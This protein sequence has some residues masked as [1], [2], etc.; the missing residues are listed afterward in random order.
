MQF[1]FRASVIGLSVLSAAAGAT[2]AEAQEGGVVVLPEIVISAT[3][4]PTGDGGI[5][6][7]KVPAD[8]TVI[9]AKD[10]AQQYKPSVADTITAR[11]PAAIA[12]NVDG[13]DL[14]PDLFYR[15]F[16]AS[17]IS[18]TA[19]GLAVYENGVRINESFGDAVNLD[20]IPPIAIASA[21][22]YT[23]NPIFGLNALGGAIVFTT[24]NGF[25]FQ[26]GDVSILGGSYGRAN[27]Y[28]EFGKQVGNY[29]FYVAGDVYRDGGYRPFGAQNAQRFLA[30]L[31]YRSQDSEIHAIGSF[32]RSLLGVQGVTPQVLVNQ[33][34]NSV[35]TTP[36]TTNNQA[37]SAQLTGRF[38][39]APHWQVA[40]NFYIRQFDQ[41]H[42]DG[43]DA[44][45]DDC[46]NIDQNGDNPGTLCQTPL[47]NQTP[48]SSTPYQFIT[49]NGGTIASQG[50]NFAYGTTARTATHTLS[51]GTQL[52]ATNNQQL[53]GHDN[54]FVVA[55]QHRCRHD[56]LFV[57]DLARCPEPAVPEHRSRLP[58]RRRDPQHRRQ[59][60][61]EL[62]LRPRDRDLLRPLRARHLQHHQAA[63]RDRRRPLQRRQHRPRRP[64]RRQSGPQL[65]GL[66]QPDQPGRRPDLHVLSGA[67]RL[68]RL[69]RGEPRPDPRSK[70]PVPT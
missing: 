42:V 16:D 12:L 37:G 61:R 18:G 64:E 25:N 13:S 46:S 26:G 19:E 60:R 53:Y 6:I 49:P 63:R 39:V 59:H 34:Y 9:S 45:V 5:D 10:F 23:N 33:Q 47:T 66:L 56:E 17:R 58:R 69:F 54:Y 32:G 36:Q 4:V 24:K 21:D 51:A 28:G 65:L 55:R 67:D 68:R 70:T 30:D 2:S 38:D 7:N 15:G 40:S 3:P 62:D 22:V 44:D 43:N 50:G 35:F 31:G 8:V 57:D 14:S 11:T 41:Y 27:A 52:Q 1:T 29:S 20:L 48:V